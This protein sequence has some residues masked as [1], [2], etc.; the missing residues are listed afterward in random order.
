MRPRQRSRG[1]H[2]RERQGLEHGCQSVTGV[3]IEDVSARFVDVVKRRIL[4]AQ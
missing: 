3:V 2:M 1:V 4:A